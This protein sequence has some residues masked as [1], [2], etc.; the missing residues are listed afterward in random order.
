MSITFYYTP[1][2]SATRVHWVLEELGV[3]YEKVK[4]DLRA[5]EQHKPEFLAINPNG[6]VPALVVDG[7]PMFESLAIILYLGD[8]FGVDKGLWPRVGTGEH[9]EALTW[10]V[11][12]SVTLG[13]TIFR[14]FFN[15]HEWFP[16]E[17]RNAA[18]AEAAR[19][20]FEAE[21]KILDQRL[22]GRDYLV[23]R[24][25]T[26]VDAANSSALAWA[27]TF[28]KLDISAYPAVAA[29]IDRCVNRP[30]NRAVSAA[31]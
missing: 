31:S 13:G 29:W 19:K 23:G 17:S 18:Q 8:R 14:I 25:F 15:T 7:T 30:A 11:W 1:R 2:T 10:I 26:L 22:T 27:L 20:E 9:A 6:K 3:R 12:G 5:G 16:A 28:I 24:D 4:V 21:L